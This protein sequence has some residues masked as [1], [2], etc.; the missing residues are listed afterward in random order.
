LR[1]IQPS[2]SSTAMTVRPTHATPNITHHS[3]VML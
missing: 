3:V 2:S 1:R